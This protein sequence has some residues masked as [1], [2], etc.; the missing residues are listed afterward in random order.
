MEKSTFKE[1]VELEDI[2]KTMP[3]ELKALI[4]KVAVVTAAGAEIERIE[5]A[6]A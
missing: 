2:I 4:A 6:S 3:K 1:I 5:A